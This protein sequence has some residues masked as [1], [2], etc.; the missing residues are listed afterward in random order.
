MRSKWQWTMIVLFASI[1]IAL[2]AVTSW[3][4]TQQPL[5]EWQGLTREP[6]RWWTIATLVD[7]YGGFLTFFAWVCFKEHRSAI[8]IAWFVA[9]MVLG[10]I[11]MASYVLWQL[12]RLDARAPASAIL[13]SRSR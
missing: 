10:N 11:A 13:T 6:D 9:I 8:R 1:W 7:A 4:S 2:V 12:M 5:W 3:A